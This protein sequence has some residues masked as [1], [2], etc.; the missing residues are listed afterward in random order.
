[1]TQ[2]VLKNFEERRRSTSETNDEW[3][4]E[5]KL[6]RRERRVT[7]A[8]IEELHT[9]F[10]K[11]TRSSAEVGLTN[12]GYIHRNCAEHLDV[13]TDPV[14][15][16]IPE[17]PAE[18]VIG[19][20]TVL[21]T[22]D[23]AQ[24]RHARNCDPHE[25]TFGKRGKNVGEFQDATGITY[26]SRDQVLVTDMVNNRMQ[27]CN[28]TGETSVVY[29]GEDI[30]EPWS[31]CLTTD[32]Y[33][34]FTSRRRKCVV[35]MSREGDILWSFGAGF[36]E[37]PCGVCVDTDG[38]FVVTD[39]FTN[40][41]SI[42]NKTGQFLKYIGNPK[43]ADQQFSKPRYVCV[44][45]RGEIIVSDSGHHRIKLFDKGGHFVRSIGKF[46]KKDGEL[47]TPYGVCTDS[48]GHILVAD[49]YN[50]RISMFTREG[51]F[52]C[53]VIE[54]SLSVKHPKGIALSPHLNLYVSSGDLKACEIKIYKLKCSDPTVIVDV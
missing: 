52:V 23:G 43:I 21:R 3:E 6:Y 27:L 11:S 2:G 35:V 15:S 31:A 20:V 45:P 10:A 50:N 5:A 17:E 47:K 51:A 25:V 24:K 44:S 22:S 7:F 54:E 9:K 39:A 40:C 19:H 38:N 53:H 33:I 46:G 36:F 1:M 14:F 34:A 41:V 28:R 49:H 30:S 4:E 42:H 13:Q 29:S 12:V 48:L 26:I 8:D 32:G 18:S 37:C 16:H